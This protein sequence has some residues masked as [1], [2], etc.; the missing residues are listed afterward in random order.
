MDV[1]QS[2]V[3]ILESLGIDHMFGGSGQVNAS[4]LLSLKKSRQIKTVIVRNE[5]AASFMACGYAMFSDKLGVCFATGGPGA[6]NLFSGMAVAYYDSLPILGITGYTSMS[7]RGKGSLNE[8]TGQNRTPDSHKMFAATTKKS[9]I[10]EHAN[11][12]CDIVEEALNIAYEG[13]PGP[14]HIH[15]PKDVTGAPVTNFR[16]ITIDIKP[17]LPQGCLAGRPPALAGRVWHS[18]RPRG[19]EIFRG[20]KFDLGARQLVRRECHFRF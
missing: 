18:G 14:V 4:M 3:R 13:R 9:Y 2:V 17:V 19:Q 8:S 5:Q 16:D 12:T 7:G 10:L 20:R 11:D 1:N 6:F 15:I